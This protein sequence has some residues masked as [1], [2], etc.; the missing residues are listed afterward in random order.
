[1]ELPTA[2]G[3]I[4]FAGNERIAS[5]DPADVA[6]KTKVFVDSGDTRAVLIFDN[7]TSEPVEIDFRGDARDVIRRISGAGGAEIAPAATPGSLP[8]RRSPGRPKLGV[9]GREVTLLPG[10]WEW[11]NAQPGGAS[12]ALRKLVEQAR[13]VNGDKDRSRRAQEAAY[14]FM[15]AIAGNEPGYEE[16]I[17]A[18]F[19]GAAASFDAHTAAWPPDVHDHARA[20]AAGAFAPA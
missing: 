15:S 12:V 14:R 9:V 19:A 7:A 3:W 16:A 5:G 17:R 4:A 10:H 8:D 11:L 20:L 13:R 1:M 18:L 2:H 6:L